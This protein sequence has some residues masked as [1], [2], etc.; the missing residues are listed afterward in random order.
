MNDSEFLLM[1]MLILIGFAA[2]IVINVCLLLWV[3]NYTR[4]QQTRRRSTEDEPDFIPVADDAGDPDEPP[5]LLE[6]VHEK[7]T[8]SVEPRPIFGTRATVRQAIM[9][10]RLLFDQS[11]KAWED[12]EDIFEAE[13]LAKL[14][15]AEVDKDAKR[16]H[17]F[18]PRILHWLAWLQ[19]QKGMI[20][21][22]E[23][24]EY[25][26]RATQIA[27]EWYEQCSDLLPHM[28]E[29]MEW[30]ERQYPNGSSCED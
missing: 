29:C 18:A 9:R 23:A 10:A 11:E 21:Y 1:A 17:W 27:L 25:W 13:R 16:D 14:A 6:A 22:Q 28:K 3:V 7:Y 2:L 30:V 26:E 20:A 8:L 4:R 5:I 12:N 15:L 24:T 19:I